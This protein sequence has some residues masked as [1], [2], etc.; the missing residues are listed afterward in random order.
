MISSADTHVQVKL[1]G[2]H[3]LTDYS[4][5]L[6]AQS[7]PLLLEIDLAQVPQ[8]SNATLHA[9]FLNAFH[10]RELRL[11]GNPNLTDDGFPNLPALLEMSA[12]E[13]ERAAAWYPWYAVTE[14]PMGKP[15]VRRPMSDVFEHLRLVDLT[16]CAGLGDVAVD[17]LVTNAPKLRNLTLAKCVRLTD[18]AVGSIGRLEKHLHYLHLGHVSS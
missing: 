13:A 5:V 3:R 4:L 16:G 9:I 10:L 14:D 1:G 11:N 2:C 8:L 15:I 12:D 17:N 7:C 6:L 18:A